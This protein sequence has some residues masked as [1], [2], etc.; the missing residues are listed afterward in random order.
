MYKINICYDFFQFFLILNV[1]VG[2]T[3]GYFPD[4]W[5]YNTPKPWK[6]TSPTQNLDFWSKSSDWLPTWNDND[7]AMIVDY[8]Q[9]TQ[10]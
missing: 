4:D 5:V 8:V 9:M 6:N 3:N 7:V 1:A 2:G 10:Y